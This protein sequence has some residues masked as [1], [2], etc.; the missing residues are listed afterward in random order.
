MDVDCDFYICPLCF[1]VSE[2]VRECHGQSM[3]HCAEL[4]PGDS[5]LKPLLDD[6][7]E[8]KSRAPR[9]FLENKKRL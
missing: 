7:G 5:R 2:T 1:A 3:I 9:W 6:E 4:E 8:L